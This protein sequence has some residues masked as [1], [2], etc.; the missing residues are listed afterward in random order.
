MI[1][2]TDNFN[3]LQIYQVV[4]HYSLK[5]FLKVSRFWQNLQHEFS[6]TFTLKF[7][8]FFFGGG[9]GLQPIFI[10]SRFLYSVFTT[11]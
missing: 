5:Y 9:G 2:A 4:S 1:P 7:L 6:T 11:E 3:K 10:L 8:G